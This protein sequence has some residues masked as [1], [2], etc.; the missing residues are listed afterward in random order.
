MHASGTH[1]T[2]QRG[3]AMEGLCACA[4]RRSVHVHF[5]QATVTV[6]TLMHTQLD[7]SGRYLIM[8]VCS[9]MMQG[10]MQTN[11]RYVIIVT[12]LT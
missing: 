9:Y 8:T 2:P 12:M 6:N 4:F 3:V 7:L 10:F 11:H 5:K 1:S